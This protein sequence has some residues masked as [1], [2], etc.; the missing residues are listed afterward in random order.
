[1]DELG[2]SPFVHFEHPDSKAVKLGLTKLGGSTGA[3]SVDIHRKRGIERLSRMT[4]IETRTSTADLDLTRMIKR[5][6]RWGYAAATFEHSN[7]TVVK[8]LKTNQF[9]ATTGVEAVAVPGQLAVTNAVAPT[10]VNSLGLT[11]EG[12]DIGKLTL[13]IS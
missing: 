10:G 5:S 4:G 3:S 2:V 1:M 7:P 9:A 11:I 8:T 13:W 6:P 12:N